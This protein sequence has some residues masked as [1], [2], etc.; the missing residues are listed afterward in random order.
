MF[1]YLLLSIVFVPI[2][3]GIVSAARGKDDGKQPSLLMY[4]SAFVIVW[5]A[6]LFVVRYK[7]A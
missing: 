5:F 3:M 7:W 2:L 1:N 6:I 4:W